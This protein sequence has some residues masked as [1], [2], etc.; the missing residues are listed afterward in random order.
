MGKIITNYYHSWVGMVGW[1]ERKLGSTINVLHTQDVKF[2]IKA[3]CCKGAESHRKRV[4]NSHLWCDSWLAFSLTHTHI[5][6]MSL[7]SSSKW[8]K[9][10]VWQ[11][12]LQ[13]TVRARSILLPS[14]PFPT[15]LHM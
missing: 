2:K 12:A 1:R 13:D 4:A 6:A 11:M 8:K 10:R 7:T 15:L 5:C 9:F 14:Q 3:V